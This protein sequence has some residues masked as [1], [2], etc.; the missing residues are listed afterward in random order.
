MTRARTLT[1]PVATSSAL[2]RVALS[3]LADGLAAS[4]APV[5]LVAISVSRLSVLAPLQLELPVE[6]NDPVRPGTPA[7]ATRLAAEEALD[8]VRERFGKTAA[9]RASLLLDK[10]EKLVPDE[11]RHLA[12]RDR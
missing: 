10:D 6:G 7:G 9:G 12:E 8:R 4:A 1:A 11:F 5:T 2:H 3:L